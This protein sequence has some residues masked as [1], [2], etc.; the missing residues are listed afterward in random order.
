[1]K[2][3]EIKDEIK[4]PICGSDAVW[5]DNPNEN[6]P[7]Y[8]GT[9]GTSECY[10]PDMVDGHWRCPNE[11]LIYASIMGEYEKS[12]SEG[13]TEIEAGVIFPFMK[14]IM[15]GNENGRRQRAQKELSS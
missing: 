1:M 6:S 12:L 5:E 9:D 7:F 14:N 8:V 10:D 3:E 15:K 11:H 13:K 4:C 2:P